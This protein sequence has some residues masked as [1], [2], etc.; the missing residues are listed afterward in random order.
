[1]NRGLQV[2]VVLLCLGFPSNHRGTPCFARPCHSVLPYELPAIN[3]CCITVRVAASDISNGRLLGHTGDLM[4]LPNRRQHPNPAE[5][6]FE[7]RHYV[8]EGCGFHFPRLPLR[9]LTLT[10]T[11]ACRSR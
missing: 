4:P 7:S 8:N 10:N 1:M 5:M 3:F 2:D 9:L 6:A 11:L